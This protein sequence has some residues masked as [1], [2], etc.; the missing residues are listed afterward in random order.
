MARQSSKS[1]EARPRRFIS[2]L[3]SNWSLAFDAEAVFGLSEINFQFRIVRDLNTSVVEPGRRCLTWRIDCRSSQ[4][5]P[6]VIRIRIL[7]QFDP[8]IANQFCP[9]FRQCFPLGALL[10][11][12]ANH[13][14]LRLVAFAQLPNFV[15][16]ISIGALA[17][18][19]SLKVDVALRELDLDQIAP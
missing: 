12:V 3:H 16:E 7:A 18:P 9:G 14:L 2:S 17:C 6:F 19:R 11:E 10:F 5:L 15:L 13:F 1:G 4:L 8:Q